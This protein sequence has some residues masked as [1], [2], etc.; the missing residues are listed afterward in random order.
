MNADLATL[1]RALE[2]VQRRQELARQ[3]QRD[4]TRLL[5]GT[6][7]HG[8]PAVELQAWNAVVDLVLEAIDAATES[9]RDKAPF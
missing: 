5:E 9:A 4:L 2:L 6:Q 8:R 3:E 7:W 1:R